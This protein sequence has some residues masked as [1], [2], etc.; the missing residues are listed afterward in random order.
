[1]EKHL[2]TILGLLSE[3]E[4]QALKEAEAEDYRRPFERA[5][6]TS[7][8][9]VSSGSL[10]V[11]IPPTPSHLCFALTPSKAVFIA[12]LDVALLTY[13]QDGL[14]DKEL[15]DNPPI[16]YE[17]AI[18]C[19]FTSM[20]LAVLAMSYYSLMAFKFY[21]N[22]QESLK[23]AHVDDAENDLK[24]IFRRLRVRRFTKF[25]DQGIFKLR[26]LLGMGP[27][28]VP[29][30]FVELLNQQGAD[31]HLSQNHDEHSSQ[32]SDADLELE[33]QLNLNLPDTQRPFSIH[34]ASW[35]N[36]MITTKIF[37]FTVVSHT[38]PSM[39]TLI[40]GLV[41]LAWARHPGMVAKVITIITS[42]FLV[43]LVFIVAA[44]S[45]YLI[46]S[47][48]VQY[49]SAAFKA[50]IKLPHSAELFA[51]FIFVVIVR[52]VVF[53]IKI[54]LAFTLQIVR[55]LINDAFLI[56]F[57]VIDN[58]FLALAL[59]CVPACV[60]VGFPLFLVF[61]VL[62]TIWAVIKFCITFVA[63]YCC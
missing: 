42:N 9:G 1:M 62:Y 28:G 58:V 29:D 8:E 17:L 23:A 19:F 37:K 57:L 26:E 24:G 3:L 55:I 15:I 51:D 21:H 10:I 54:L 30:K 40:V 38:W 41:L 63:T 13:V 53:I 39:L 18:A 43:D 31:K 52:P 56:I 45:T 34:T 2:K 22:L 27:L 7:M 20:L 46:L 61:M 50:F 48:L 14:S 5:A 59:A 33:E 32:N 6:K 35:M 4:E 25:Y 44:D 36:A 16:L 12:A 60:V 47:D 11:R 49:I